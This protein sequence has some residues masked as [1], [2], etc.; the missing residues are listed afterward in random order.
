MIFTFLLC[1]LSYKNVYALNECTSSELQRLR[2]LANNVSFTY[3][4]KK[5]EYLEEDTYTVKTA[6]YSVTAHNLSD[7]LTVRL[8]NDNS[9]VFTK[10]KPTLNN[11]L[12][13]SL[14]QIELVAYTKNLCSGRVIVTKNVELPYWNKYSEREECN[15]YPE[16]KYC[17]EFG[18]YNI[19]DEEFL[20]ELE[21]YKGKD[22]K[23]PDTNLEE[24]SLTKFFGDYGL[25]FLGGLGGVIVIAF[26][27]VFILKKRK[28]DSDL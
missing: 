14:V 5:E 6:Y 13:G 20:S 26:L 22:E 19:T 10:E 11:F 24:N 1:I 18:R 4:Y 27:I 25:Y 17:S 16:F 3:E 28:K 15:L 23:E 12:N 8:K 9:L 2:E 7:E 21:K